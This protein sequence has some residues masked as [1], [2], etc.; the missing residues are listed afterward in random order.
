MKGHLI[1]NGTQ[2]TFLQ[3]HS[4]ILDSFCPLFMG[5]YWAH[6]HTHVF[7]LLYLSYWLLWLPSCASLLY[8]YQLRQLAD[9]TVSCYP[10]NWRAWIQTHTIATH[11]HVTV[12]FVFAMHW[13]SEDNRKKTF[14]VHLCARRQAGTK[15]QNV[16]GR[17]SAHLKDLIRNTGSI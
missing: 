13:S 14:I 16:P 10:H 15:W 12:T 2:Q 6:F 4:G 7:L 17:K 11:T 8:S 5:R 3:H 9:V 1:H